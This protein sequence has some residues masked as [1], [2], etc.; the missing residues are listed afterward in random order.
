MHNLPQFKKFS[1]KSATLSPVPWVPL[2]ANS[3]PQPAP[4]HVTGSLPKNAS[5]GS[6]SWVPALCSGADWGLGQL[7]EKPPT[8]PSA[9]LPLWCFILISLTVPWLPPLQ[10]PKA[11]GITLILNL[12]YNLIFFVFKIVVNI[13]NTRFYRVKHWVS[14]PAGSGT[15]PWSIHETFSSSQMEALLIKH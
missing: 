4:L 11:W 7:W 1:F 13:H 8:I 14:N 15:S 9:V 5:L 3:E 12:F 10:A 6:P 2:L